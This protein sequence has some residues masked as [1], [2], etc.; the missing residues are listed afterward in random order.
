MVFLIKNLIVYLFIFPLILKTT[1]NTNKNPKLLFA[2][3]F[4][5]KILK[6][7]H[8]N[9]ILKN[10]KKYYKKIFKTVKI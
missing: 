2:Q 6:I 1:K 4:F 9:K 10:D 8:A 3:S 5:Y 7:K